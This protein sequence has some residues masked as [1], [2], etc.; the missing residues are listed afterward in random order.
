MEKFSNAGDRHERK[1]KDFHTK[2]E[3][4]VDGKYL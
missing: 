4:Q 3:N 1:K 2:I